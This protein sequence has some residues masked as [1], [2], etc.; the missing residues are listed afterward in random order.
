VRGRKTWIA[1]D[2]TEVFE[3]SR[4]FFVEIEKK[5]AKNKLQVRFVL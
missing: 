2:F 1:D 4:K 3:D 5:R